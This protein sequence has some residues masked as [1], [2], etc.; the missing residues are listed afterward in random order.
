MRRPNR[1]NNEIKDDQFVH[2]QK[3]ILIILVTSLMA[4]WPVIAFLYLLLYTINVVV[5][6]PIRPNKELIQYK[7][8][9]CQ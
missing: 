5:E 6:W 4:V 8:K 7:H 9:L 2:G 1:L 3:K